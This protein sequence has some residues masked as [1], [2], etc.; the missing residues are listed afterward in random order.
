M[1]KEY[2][3]PQVIDFSIEAVTGIGT[4]ITSSAC[5]TGG[6]YT[7]PICVT[8]DGNTT[9]CTSGVF[10]STGCDSQGSV[11][12]STGIT[13]TPGSSAQSCSSNGAGASGY[14]SACQT[15]SIPSD[16]CQSGGTALGNING[17][18]GFGNSPSLCFNGTSDVPAPHS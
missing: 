5:I 2:C 3:K 15:G 18:W 14:R 8:G 1:K 7:G 11:P 13:C 10:L 17:C 6:G 9:A 12:Y 16:Y 4:G